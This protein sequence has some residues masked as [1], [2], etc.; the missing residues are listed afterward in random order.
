M[1]VSSKLGIIIWGAIAPPVLSV[2]TAV[3]LASVNP[4][5]STP[6]GSW[7]LPR[8][9]RCGRMT[10][11][12]PSCGH[13]RRP[14]TGNRDQRHHRSVDWSWLC[15]HAGHTLCNK[16]ASRPHS[17]INQ[18]TI[19]PHQTLFV[20]TAMPTVSRKST[21]RDRGSPAPLMESLSSSHKGSTSLRA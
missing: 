15:G 18:R 16:P 5:S 1:T 10:R 4:S 11:W 13:T 9:L 14:C 6:A 12:P 20:Y 7:S 3:P 21:Q 17:H 2:P 19:L 8:G